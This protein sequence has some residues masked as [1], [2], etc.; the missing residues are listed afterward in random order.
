MTLY[1]SDEAVLAT[2][3]SSNNYWEA[4]GISIDSRK[5]QAG[6]LFIAIVGENTDGHQYVKSALENGA[7]AAVVNYVPE[8]LSDDANLLVVEDTFEALW[9]LAR[10]SRKR[11]K[12]KVIMVTGSVG[13]TTTKE[14]LAHALGSQGKIH[15][16]IGNLNNHYGL[17]LTLCRML[18][19]TDYAILEVGMSSAGEISPLS[20]LAQPDV[21]IITTVEAV[22]LEFFDSVE[23]IAT[24]KAEVF[25]G[26]IE[27]GTAVLNRDNPHYLFL[28]KNASAKGVKNIVTFGQGQDANLRLDEY[29][30][31][32]EYSSIKASVNGKSLEYKLGVFGK[33]HALNSLGVLALVNAVGANIEQAADSFVSFEAKEG[34]G[35]RLT[36]DGKFG[37]VTIIDDTYNA[38]PASVAASLKVLGDIK[39]LHKNRIIAVLGDMFELGE[40]APKMHADLAKNIIDNNVDVVFTAGKLTQ[41]LYN[42]LPDKIKGGNKEESVDIAKDVFKS[43]KNGDVI[44]VKGSRGMKM[45]N[46]V[47]YIAQGKGMK[48]AV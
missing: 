31:S 48:N 11:L 37:K 24:A 18:A 2:G 25:D 43:L 45:E 39:M 13:K 20:V 32:L 28:K 19:D 22:H 27:G 9:S 40:T 35:K 44:L 4:T 15:A 8:G 42:A 46:V 10:F 3:G 29:K 33:H 7:V 47:N 14:M 23:G 30:E 21:V 5:I 26:L 34:R 1:N 38:S 6:D 16:T 41:N 17:P 36:V 12:G